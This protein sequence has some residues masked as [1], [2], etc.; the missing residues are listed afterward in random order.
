[1]EKSRYLNLKNQSDST[2][3]IPLEIHISVDPSSNMFM[4][5]DT[6]IGMTKEE[7]IQNLGTIA[8]SGTKRFVETLQEQQND[9]Q[10]KNQ[11]NWI[12]QF[13]VGFYSCFM[14]SDEI[15]VYS[16]SNQENSIG[17]EWLSSNP[18]SYQITEAEKVQKGTKII[19]KLKESCKSFSDPLYVTKII[20]H[21]SHFVNFPIYLNQERINKIQALWNMSPKEISEEEYINF[22]QF[23]TTT[24]TRPF[25]RLHFGME[26][27]LFMKGI[28]YVPEQHTEKFGSQVMDFGVDLYSRRILIESKS[29]HILPRW[30]RFLKGV[31]DCED[32]SLNVSRESV[33][34]HIVLKKLQTILTLRILRWFSD[35]LKNDRP[36]FNQFY[37][38]YRLFL[39]EGYLTDQEHREEIGTLLQFESSIQSMDDYITL[40]EYV[41]RMKPNQEAI[42]YLCSSHRQFAL[43]SCYF[44]AF[45]RDSNASEVLFSYD[46]IDSILLKEMSSFEGKPLVNIE[47]ISSNSLDEKSTKPQP[48]Q[49]VS[50]LNWFKTSL[51]PFVEEVTISNRLINSPAVI[52]ADELQSMQRM[53]SKIQPQAKI[54]AFTY[55][56]EINPEHEIIKLIDEVRI[57][58][59]ELAKEVA[60]QIFDNALLSA[61]LFEDARPMLKRMNTLLRHILESKKKS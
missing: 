61:G 55:K 58:E 25:Y 14:V 8:H 53:W 9:K 34:D 2:Q 56:I 20:N 54:G 49:Y 27:P 4:I 50:L 59:P 24:S 28:L 57:T 18:G 3:E 12:G 39:K 41:N 11:K 45:K 29:D 6:G 22:Y 21:Y 33:Q 42:Y 47:T 19:L 38:E 15:R 1:L 16:G 51:K 13:G 35:E 40:S 32:I 26:I 36:L 23:L 48:Q 31:V 30:L 37:K 43:D 52:I 17:H 7:M 5:Q 60:E 10:M 46:V 44:E